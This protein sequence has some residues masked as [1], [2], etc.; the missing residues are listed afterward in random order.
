MA[1]SIKSRRGKKLRQKLRERYKKKADDHLR[2]IVE[3]AQDNDLQ[4]IT[5]LVWIPKYQRERDNKDEM[6]NEEA[7]TSGENAEGD[8]KDEVKME[9]DTEP[10]GHRPKK[11]LRVY[12]GGIECL[13][14]KNGGL[15]KWLSQ[16]KVRKAFIKKK[17]RKNDKAKRKGL[18][19]F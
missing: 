3:K 8:V 17:I 19:L 18:K 11:K 4:D 14:D 6:V 16:R 13:R 15:P 5:T 1:R 7:E 10:K 9:G 2:K 12:R